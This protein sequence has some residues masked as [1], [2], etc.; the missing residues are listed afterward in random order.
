MHTRSAVEA[1][2]GAMDALGALRSTAEVDKALD[3]APLFAEDEGSAAHATLHVPLG[4]EYAAAARDGLCNNSEAIAAYAT[5]AW[6]LRG[7][8]VCVD[9]KTK[10]L[11][12]AA[13][14]LNAA[15]DEL[16]WA[17]AAAAK[18]RLAKGAAVPRE[19]FATSSPLAPRGVAW[20]LANGFDTPLCAMPPANAKGLV[21]ALRWA[22]ANHHRWHATAGTAETLLCTAARLARRGAPLPA[23]PQELWLLVI[24]L[25]AVD[26]RCTLE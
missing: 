14:G 4:S 7:Y 21:A 3:A 2:F 18:G 11:P 13:D 26:D 6:A 17:V 25:T 10:G 8:G 23:L 22:P 16:H 24:E 5:A 12:A 1:Y 20:A 15:L 9:V 19:V